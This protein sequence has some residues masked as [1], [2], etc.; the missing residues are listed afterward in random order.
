MTS[1]IQ[2][3][4]IWHRPSLDEQINRHLRRLSHQSAPAR[5]TPILETKN[6]HYGTIESFNDPKGYGFL[7]S[8]SPLPGIDA[9]KSVYFHRTKAPR[10]VD[11]RAGMRVEFQLVEA[12]LPN[13]PMQAKILR[14]IT[15]MAEAA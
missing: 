9:D 5:R 13:K 11:L 7:A 10:G 1:V 15:E 6:V 4:L 12:H 3:E 2:A 14:V 8:D